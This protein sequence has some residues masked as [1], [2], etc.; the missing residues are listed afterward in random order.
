MDDAL[1]AGLLDPND[2]RVY[3]EYGRTL[4]L[5]KTFA[6]RAEALAYCNKYKKKSLWIMDVGK[7]TMQH[8]SHFA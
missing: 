1:L 2:F 4:L 8:N 5:R 6:T 3:L 7:S